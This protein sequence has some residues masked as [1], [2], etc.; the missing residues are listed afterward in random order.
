MYIRNRFC[1]F[2]SNDVKKISFASSRS[3]IYYPWLLV[4]SLVLI[5]IN[6]KRQENL[7]TYLD[8]MIL[9]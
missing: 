4:V 7:L 1:V 2:G 5:P 3:A 8:D 6:K 9:Y